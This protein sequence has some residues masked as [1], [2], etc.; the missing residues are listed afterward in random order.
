[1][2]E[3]DAFASL[4]LSRREALWQ[5]QAIRGTEPLPLF[6][7]DLEG[8]GLA[9]PDVTLPEM[10]EGEHVVEDYVSMRLTLRSHPMA[11]LRKYLTPPIGA[12]TEVPVSRGAQNV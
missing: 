8:E 12:V 3:A 10:T 9:E 6:A 2:A 11:L 4:G 5:A 1:M 7:R